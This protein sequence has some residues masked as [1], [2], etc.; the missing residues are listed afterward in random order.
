MNR[1][2]KEKKAEVTSAFLMKKYPTA[3]LASQLFSSDK[4]Q[5]YIPSRN[6]SFNY[7]LGGGAGYGKILEIFGEESSGKTLAAID[8]AYVTQSLGGA[9]IWGD[10]EQSF[11]EKWAKQNGLD[12]SKIY[13]YPETAIEHISDWLADMASFLRKQLVNNEP[14]L[15]VCDSIAALDC[16]ENINSTQTDAKAEMGNRAKAIYKM[17]RIRNQLLTELGVASIYINQIR[18]KLGTTQWEDPDT[19]P[20]GK[21]MKFY[22]SQRIGFYAGKQIKDK[23]NGIET[24]VGAWTSIRV[25]K[26][27][28]APPRPTIKTMMYFNPDYDKPL[29]F[30]RYH[31]LAGILLVTGVLSKKSG[32]SMYYYK[33]KLVAR[34]EDSLMS[35]L[36]SDEELRSTLIRRSGINSTSRTRAQLEKLTTN[37]FKVKTLKH[38]KQAGS[39]KPE[40]EQ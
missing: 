15:F 36:S 30:D 40:G 29:G 6:I 32:S 31:G 19:T 18:H 34:G 8:L 12:L 35:K 16:L 38:E 11:T 13:I 28:L 14:I 1:K 33:D 23:I 39:S 9:V 24:R 22:A 37:L 3:G 10:A 4:P 7:Q 21:A 2:P 5:L 27:K 20:G 17:V 25:K 26:N